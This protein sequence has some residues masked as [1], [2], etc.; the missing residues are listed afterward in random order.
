MTPAHAFR[1]V[2]NP[3]QPK[4]ESRRD[5]SLEIALGLGILLVVLGNCLSGLLSSDI[6]PSELQ[7]PTL[8]VFVINL[9]H[10]PLLFLVL[11]H[12]ASGTRRTSRSTLARLLPTLVYPYFLWSM[13]EGLVRVYLS[14]YTGNPASIASLYKILWIP[15]GHYWFLYALFLCQAGY[16]I[17][18]RLSP[19]AQLAIAGIVFLAPQF[20]LNP[21][22]D[23]H[24]LIVL[25]TVRGFFYFV[26]GAVSVTQVKQFGRWT[27]I[28]ATVLFALFSVMDYQ[29]QLAGAI[30]APAALPAGIAGI[31]AILACSRMMAAHQGWPARLIAFCGRYWMGIYILHIFFTFGARIALQRLAVDTWTP[32]GLAAAIEILTASVLAIAL[33][34]A[35]NWA[36]SKFSL[37]KWLG[38]PHME[39]S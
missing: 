9:F 31:I 10:M 27:A 8:T 32:I 35:I 22:L 34:L 36:A 12:L 16:L 23:A 6:F 39:T 17:I 30:A 20:F 24:L 26:L 33:P 25:E 18:R 3:R 7:W 14:D 29:S 37:D 28:S 1:I 11:G 21:I 19:H 13:L 15:I 2:T 38:L 4:P 5:L